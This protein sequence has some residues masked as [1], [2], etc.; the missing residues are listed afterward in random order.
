MI[1]NLIV[2]ISGMRVAYITPNIA[3]SNFLNISP[4]LIRKSLSLISM[5]TFI[6]VSGYIH[7]QNFHSTSFVTE[8]TSSVIY[9]NK[10]RRL[11]DNSNRDVASGNTEKLSIIYF[12][13]DE[14]NKS[15]IRGNWN[16]FNY[17][18]VDD[19]EEKMDVKVKMRLIGNSTVIIDEDQDQ[20]FRIS[21]MPTNN[22]IALVKKMEEGFEIIEAEKIIEKKV[23]KKKLNKIKKVKTVTKESKGPNTKKG[24][25]LYDA[26][27]V[28]ENVLFPKKSREILRGDSIRGSLSLLDGEI[29]SLEVEV[30][31]E[32]GESDYLEIPFAD[33]NDGGQFQVETDEGIVSGIITNNGKKSYRVRV[34][35]GKMKGAILNFVIEGYEEEVAVIPTEANKRQEIAYVSRQ[36]ENDKHFL[37]KGQVDKTIVSLK[38]MKDQSYDF[39]SNKPIREISSRP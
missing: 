36:I 30:N 39:S 21:F 35:T 14:L 9:G 25:R 32:D 28:L 24:I 37:K 23:I 17:I 22:M 15:I 2:E 3:R 12:P 33:I 18:S 8:T 13:V 11:D 10:S 16:I 5:S 29:Q 26:D 1:N 19:I 6:I 38:K 7:D 20:I 31:Y 4:F 34:A 27:L